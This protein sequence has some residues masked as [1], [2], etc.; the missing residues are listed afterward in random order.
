MANGILGL[1]GFATLVTVAA[2]RLTLEVYRDILSALHLIDKASE[3]TTL[4]NVGHRARVPNNRLKDRLAE[5]LALGF[6][7]VNGSV[8]KRGYKYLIEFR[9][10]VE[11]FLRKFHLG[12]AQMNRT[13]SLL[14]R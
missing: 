11:P 12:G 8:T 1:A 5:L 9:N 14:R 6:V 7:D 13:S 10:D 3:R 2:D 4:Y